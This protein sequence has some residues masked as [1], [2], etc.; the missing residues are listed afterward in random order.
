MA[1]VLAAFMSLPLSSLSLVPWTMPRGRPRIALPPLA[2]NG[3]DLMPP[4]V[5]EEWFSGIEAIDG[6]NKELLELLQRLRDQPFFRLYSVDLLNGCGYMPQEED[7]C[8]SVSCEVFPVDSDRVPATVRDRDASEYDFELDGWVRWDMPSED[9]Y[10]CVEIAETYTAYDG[11]MVWN[12]IHSKICFEDDSGEW[13]MDFN[14]AVSGLHA[15]ISAHI[16]DGMKSDTSGAVDAVKEYERRLSSSGEVPE[17]IENLYFGYMLLLCAVR[18]ASERLEK[19]DFGSGSDEETDV[20]SLV[21]Q[22]LQSPLV[23]DK[24]VE[25]AELNMRDHA[26]QP[27]SKLWQARL[28]TRDLL[29]IMDCVQCNV[30]RLHGK[31]G[32]LGI[33]TSMQVLLGAEGRGGDS[34]RLHRVEIAALVTTLGKFSNAIRI[35]TEMEAARRGEDT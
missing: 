5:T 15:C 17:A 34:S 24:G 28:R 19:Y 7:E 33:A 4:G 9:Y 1:V 27:G 12:F 32:A 11:S 23:L 13:Q 2:V 18:E 6:Y 26:V 3:R 29:R 20:K 14:R 16:V 35:V 30:C 21:L 10:D 31:V 25:V 22:L 8:E